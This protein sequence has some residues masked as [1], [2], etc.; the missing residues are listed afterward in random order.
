MDEGLQDVL[1]RAIEAQ[2]GPREPPDRRDLGMLGRFFGARYASTNIAGIVVAVALAMLTLV[3]FF[4]GTT[5]SEELPNE[6]EIVTG[7]FS[8]ISLVLGY[9]FGSAK[10]P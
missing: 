9:L 6:R 4:K 1:A 3:V 5:T 8:L 7:A 2:R 10:K